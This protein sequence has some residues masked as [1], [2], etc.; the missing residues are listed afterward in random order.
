MGNCR[1]TTHLIQSIMSQKMDWWKALAE[2]VDNGFDAGATAVQIETSAQHLVVTDNGSGVRDVDCLLTL[3]QHA[4]KP[5]SIGIYGVG[6]KDAW[7]S[8]A[9]VMH[10]DSVCDGQRIRGTYDIKDIISRN[11][12]YDE[13][14]VTAADQ[15]QSYTR[16]RF[17]LRPSKNPPSKVA[18]DKLG[19]AFT[20]AIQQ[21]Y[22]IVIKQ[23]RGAV[24]M[25]PCPLP[26][27][28][29]VV[30][31]TFSVD[32]RSV[33]IRIGLTDGTPV[34]NGP[35]WLVFGHRII[36]GTSLGT[37][38]YGI[39]NIA[40][41]ITLAPEWK[42]CLTK[43]KDDLT[44]DTADLEDAI[45]SRIQ[46]LLEE[47]QQI[48]ETFESTLLTNELTDMLNTAVDKTNKQGTGKRRKTKEQ[49][50]TVEPKDSGRKHS[51]AERVNENSG[52]VK[53][54][55]SPPTKRRRG[56]HIK[57]YSDHEKAKLGWFDSVANCVVL[58]D[59]NRFI[60]SRRPLADRTG[61]V[62]T[63]IAVI[64]DY[65]AR[66]PNGKPVLQF[67]YSSFA[68]AYGAMV[69]AIAEVTHVEA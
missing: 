20:P 69:D 61:I 60:E 30:D 4:E 15:K 19:W 16:L 49:D 28:T 64:A 43:H 33:S 32:G 66:N 35:L 42:E 14:S 40:G 37:G 56:I 48:S 54:R 51:F 46:P 6:C 1:P 53:E 47:A 24:A 59:Q 68:D 36:S 39:R 41:T 27:L 31:D 57:W 50:G 13:P 34:M 23:R 38:S 21:G 55:E 9:D 22:A 26:E 17:D 63:A 7:L 29:D 12:D 8:C 3:G 11:F 5:S 62:C 18:F 52:D 2:L 45:F 65:Q 25:S 58:N 67:S 10:V 44:I